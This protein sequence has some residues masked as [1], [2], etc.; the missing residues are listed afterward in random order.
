MVLGHVGRRSKCL[1]TTNLKK[2][3]RKNV[4]VARK[5]KEA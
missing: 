1:I 3:K 2:E 5:R 4:R